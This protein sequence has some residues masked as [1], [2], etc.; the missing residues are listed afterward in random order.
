MM[1]FQSSTNK[2]E[3]QDSNTRSTGRLQVKYR[4]STGGVQWKTVNYRT[5]RTSSVLQSTGVSLFLPCQQVPISR[6][7]KQT[8]V[9]LVTFQYFFVLFGISSY[10]F[11]TS[12]YFLVLLRTFLNFYTSEVGNPAFS[13]LPE[14]LCLHLYM[15]WNLL[16][17]LNFLDNDW[18]KNE[19]D[20]FLFIFNI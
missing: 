20:I 3:K 14:L 7:R 19:I 16:Y 13:P 17:I 11:G 4:W 5:Q 18:Y 15:K 8:S 9:L 10:F 6:E 1:S 2:V 12:S